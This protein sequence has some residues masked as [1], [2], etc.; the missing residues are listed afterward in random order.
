MVSIRLRTFGSLPAPQ[1]E[2]GKE[3]DHNEKTSHCTTQTHDHHQL[4]CRIHANHIYTAG[5]NDRL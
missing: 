4:R 1:R 2:Y 5:T 3:D